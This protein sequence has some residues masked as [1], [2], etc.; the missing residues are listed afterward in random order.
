MGGQGEIGRGGPS[1]WRVVAVSAGAV[2]LVLWAWSDWDLWVLVPVL[3]VMVAARLL[4]GLVPLTW[5]DWVS[6]RALVVVVV[7]PVVWLVRLVPWPGVGVAVGVGGL[8]AVWQL[9][10]VLPVGP[11]WAAVGVSAALVAVCGVVA[12]WSWSEARERREA[13]ERAEREFRVADMRP[14]TPLAVLHLMVKAVHEAD[15][16]LVC[17]H[18]FTPEAERQFARAVGAEGC[19]S[20]V[21]V[22]HGQITGAGYGN[23]TTSGRDAVAE[24]GGRAASVSGCRMYVVDGPLSYREPPGPRLGVFRLARDPRFPDTGYQVTGYTPCEQADQEDPTTTST[25]P[26]VLPSYPPSFAGIVARA[27]A[28]NDPAVCDLFTPQ[29]AVQFAATVTAAS[30]PDAVAVLAGRVTDPTA[31]GTPSGVTTT[32]TP[33]GPVVNACALTWN[34]WGTG[35]ITAGPQLGRFTLT[36]PKPDTPGYLI[37]TVSG[38]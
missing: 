25:P 21:A 7:V 3:V 38:C 12:V 11:R 35:S 31:Y 2:A 4:V 30:C 6:T 23:A 15:P 28:G 10:V 14:A 27:V 36:H 1:W 22:L 26:P 9:R 13:N 29:G 17:F 24:S 37:D 20:A 18:M 8:V 34:R 33:D 5:R 32:D 19:A 16:A